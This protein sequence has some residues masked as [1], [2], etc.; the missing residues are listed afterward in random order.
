ML[1]EHAFSAFGNG[2]P[3]LNCVWLYIVVGHRLLFFVWLVCL[4]SG[5]NVVPTDV[6]VV[7]CQ[8]FGACIPRGA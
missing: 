2:S 7:R 6:G 1:R 8:W 5:Y 4:V 3:L